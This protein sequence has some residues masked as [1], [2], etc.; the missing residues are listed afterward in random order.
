MNIFSTSILLPVINETFSLKQ[1]VDIIAASSAEYVEEYIIICCKKTTEESRKAIK[2]LQQTYDNK[3]V[4]LEQTLPFLGGAVRDAFNICRGTHV[5][6]MASDLE[7]DPSLVKQLIEESRKTPEMI[8]TATRWKG[9]GFKGYNHV[10]LIF[11]FLFQKIFS[12][13]YGVSLSDMTFGYRIFPT[14]LV[15]SIRWEEVRH[16]FLF[17]TV[18]KP[19]RLGVKVK[20]IPSVW[21]ARQEGESANTFFRNFEYFKTGIRIRFYSKNKILKQL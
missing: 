13:L 16:P 11:N 19:L 1:T 2:D 14:K 17:E 6:M 9:G 12:L 21:K 7:T 15:R 8:I 4:V 3:I 20:E 18:L 5:I 10:K